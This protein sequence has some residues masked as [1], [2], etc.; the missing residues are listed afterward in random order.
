MVV[1][2]CFFVAAWTYPICVNFVP[3]YRNC[4]DAY[5]AVDVGLRPQGT[6]A[7]EEKGSQQMT[8]MVEEGQ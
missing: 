4:A 1:P 3:S 7:D 8:E 6:G 2:L 5:T